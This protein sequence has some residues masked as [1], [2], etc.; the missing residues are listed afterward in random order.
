[1]RSRLVIGHR[2]APSLKVENSLEGVVEALR[3]GVDGVEVDVRATKDGSLVAFHD[4]SL[5]RILGVNRLV[6]EVEFD[7]LRGLGLARGFTV[8]TIEEVVDV[9]VGKAMMVLDVKELRAVKGLIELLKRVGRG[10]VVVSSFD[11][12]IPLMV[13]SEAPFVEAGII[14][15]ARPLSLSRLLHE[16]VSHLFLKKD[17]VDL[18]LLEEARDLGVTVH[19]WVV[20]NE[21]EAERLWSMGARGMVTDL[22]QLLV[23]RR[24]NHGP[25]TR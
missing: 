14:L 23:G 5:S 1:L 12:R 21:E 2:G 19:V 16:E 3:L 25:S 22:P 17:Y 13:K 7:E 11:H 20:N 24:R 15:S 18:E 8:P 10:E 6:S 4:Q 9:V